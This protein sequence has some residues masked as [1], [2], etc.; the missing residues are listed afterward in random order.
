[1]PGEGKYGGKNPKDLQSL[2]GKPAVVPQGRPFMRRLFDLLKG[3]NRF[4]SFLRINKHCQ[5]DIS[6]WRE[7][8]PAWDGVYF[9]DL[10]EYAPLPDFS[11]RSDASGSKGFGVYYNGEWFNGAWSAQ[12]Q[13]LGIAYK[14]L[15]PITIAYHVW[16]REWSRKRIWFWCDNESIVSVITSGTSKDGNIMHLLRTIFLT[17]LQHNIISQ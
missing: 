16:A 15:F 3:A 13:P 2:V 14:E 4:L 10:P 8:L 17:T 5:L 9:F 1:M 12:Q 7:F 11:L 6:W